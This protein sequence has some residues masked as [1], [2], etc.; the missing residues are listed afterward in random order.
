MEL[1]KKALIWCGAILGGGAIFVIIVYAILRN[2][3][4]PTAP[5]G[6]YFLKSI[7][8]RTDVGYEIVEQFSDKAYFVTVDDEGL[9]ISHSED[10]GIMENDVGYVVAVVGEELAIYYNDDDANLAYQGYYKDGIMKI[11]ITSETNLFR[12]TYIL[13]K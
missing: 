12:Y 10:K 4:I 9:L 11:E 3:S 5:A 6:E 13:E 1:W 2:F 7:E 8:V